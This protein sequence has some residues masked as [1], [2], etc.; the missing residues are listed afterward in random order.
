VYGIGTVAWSVR[1]V[2]DG[3]RFLVTP[4]ARWAGPREHGR[5]AARSK[6]DRPG[7][8]SEQDDE[9]NHVRAAG[10]GVLDPIEANSAATRTRHDE[11]YK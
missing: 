6:R 9:L 5:Q 2:A 4:C 11:W 3:W 1:G 8:A 7:R 10:G